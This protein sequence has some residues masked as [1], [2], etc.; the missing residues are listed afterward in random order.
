MSGSQPADGP[1]LSLVALSARPD[2][3]LAQQQ[4]GEFLADQAVTGRARY[5]CELV[6]EECLANLFEHA[7]PARPG[8]PVLVDVTVRLGSAAIEMQFDDNAQAF[9]PTQRAD[10][11]LPPSLDEARPGGLGL[12]L[13]RRWAR[14]VD[15]RSHAAGNRLLVVIDSR[16]GRAP[17]V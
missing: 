12:L 6:L 8:H 3:A 13:L 1:R 16:A 4:L 11:A 14:Q 5:A 7:Q 10:P 17:T 2:L 9:D 15:Y